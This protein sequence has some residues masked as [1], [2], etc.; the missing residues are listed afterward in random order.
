MREQYVV[1]LQK[2]KALISEMK[3]KCKGIVSL[4]DVLAKLLWGFV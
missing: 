3:R 1:N 4:L 2:R